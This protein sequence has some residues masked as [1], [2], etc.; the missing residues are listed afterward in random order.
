VVN[1]VGDQIERVETIFEVEE[2]GAK[3]RLLKNHYYGGGHYYVLYAEDEGSSV[4][5]DVSPEQLADIAISI[6]ID[7]KRYLKR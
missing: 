4:D 1:I 6:L 7:L 5:V 2:D 3:L